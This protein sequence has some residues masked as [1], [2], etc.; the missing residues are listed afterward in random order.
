MPRLLATIF[1]PIIIYAAAT[2]LTITC[3][4]LS[5]AVVIVI[6]EADIIF[7]GI[8]IAAS[9]I[10]PAAESSFLICIVAASIDPVNMLSAAI[11]IIGIIGGGLH[12]MY[13]IRDSLADMISIPCALYI[14]IPAAADELNPDATTNELAVFI[15]PMLIPLLLSVDNVA[16]NIAIGKTRLRTDRIYRLCALYRAKII[17][18]MDIIDELIIYTRDIPGLVRI[19]ISAVIADII[20]IQL[21]VSITRY[22]ITVITAIYTIASLLI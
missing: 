11:S 8:I 2:R 16:A 3:V 4:D 5:S 1:G 13:A 10:I 21:I 6:L 20:L 22:S 18:A 9:I 14:S 19:I 12:R 7:S 15:D 17:P